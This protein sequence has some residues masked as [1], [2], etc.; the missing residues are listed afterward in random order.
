MKNRSLSRLGGCLCT[1]ALIFGGILPTVSATETQEFMMHNKN[2]ERRANTASNS[3]TLQVLS[4]EGV[5]QVIDT[6]SGKQF[7]W[8]IASPT[9]S[10]QRIFKVKSDAAVKLSIDE[11]SGAVV[12]NLNGTDTALINSPWAY[13]ANGVPQPTH[14]EVN[15]DTFTQIVETNGEYTAYPITADPRV[16]WGIVSGH[17]YF[18]KEETRRVAAGAASAAAISPF[19]VLVPPPFG[20]ALGTWWANNSTNITIWATAAVAQNKCLAL[21]VGATGQVTPPSLGISSEHYTDGC[22]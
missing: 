14:Y 3:F 2:A 16:N 7:E 18:S 9:E 13:D 17:I 19:W 22:V 11:T 20:E 12:V 1:F 8:K 21:K 4:D 10:H 15:G 5:E 6:P